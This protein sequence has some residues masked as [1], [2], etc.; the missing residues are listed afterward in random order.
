MPPLASAVGYTLC[1]CWP[2]STQD[3]WREE[4][5]PCAEM[6]ACCCR[7]LL[8]T[9]VPLWCAPMTNANLCERSLSSSEGGGGAGAARAG[10]S[11]RASRAAR[12]N[13]CIPQIAVTSGW[14]AG[15]AQDKRERNHGLRGSATLSVCGCGWP[16]GR[17]P[18]MRRMSSYVTSSR[19]TRS[20]DSGSSLLAFSRITA[21]A[22]LYVSVTSW[23]ACGRVSA[24]QHM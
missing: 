7:M 6:E 22:R 10:R 5:V 21:S 4:A 12:S 8:S 24:H 16:C 19:S 1:R 11:A 17:G 15:A 23:A 2:S 14:C 13:E 3:S 20:E 9:D 18:R